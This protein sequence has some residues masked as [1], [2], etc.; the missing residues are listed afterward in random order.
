MKRY[1][2]LIVLA[3]LI[4]VHLLLAMSSLSAWDFGRNHDDGVYAVTAKSLAETGEY[5][6]ISLPGQPPQRKYP[7]VFP[8]I[9]SVVWRLRPGF[10]GNVLWL[11]MVSVLSLGVFMAVSYGLL[12]RCSELSRWTCL[13]VVGLCAMAP[14]VGDAA[15]SVMSGL[16]YGAFSLG[17]LWLI[18]RAAAGNA[19]W[20]TGIAIG[21]LAGCAYITRSIGLALLLALVVTF[22]WR[23]RWAILAGGLA[24]ALALVAPLK[25]L[26]APVGDVPR[27]FEYYVNYGDWFRHSMQDVGWGSLAMVPVKNLLVGGLNLARVVLPGG[28]DLDATWLG[29]VIVVIAL[30]AAI[31]MVAGLARQTF[32]RP[33]SPWALYLGFYLGIVLLWP[34]PPPPRFF[35]PVLPLIVLACWEGL[36]KVRLP[37]WALKAAAVLAV[38]GLAI[39]F[40]TA[41]FDRFE[42]AR[43]APLNRRYDWIRRNTAPDDVIACVLD[44]NCYLHTGR[45]AVSIAIAEVAPFYGPEGQ[46]VIR[47][48]SILRMIDESD[49]R[50]L[51]LEPFPGAKPLEDL[52]FDAVE[53]LRKDYPGLLT[54]VWDDS[55][56]RAKIYRIDGEAL[57]D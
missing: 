13:A 8:A 9:L 42:Q 21:L 47:P 22:V 15:N 31:T 5:R 49:A 34:F 29:P 14:A 52:A 3:L 30:L 53:Q 57:R 25:L 27:T 48:R 4:G 18:E 1:A 17:A 35:V 32:R 38:A 44:P 41:L 51:M 26:C 43:E 16:V 28:S 55:D 19:S 40:Q 37:A 56:V 36:R 54:E 33:P 45:K 7:I 11:K 20:K 10:P 2:H 39:A 24:G 50:Y 12:R 46:F 23:R 6:I